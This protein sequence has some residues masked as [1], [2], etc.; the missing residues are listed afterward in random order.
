M[1]YYLSF[2]FLFRRKENEK[3]TKRKEKP[4]GNINILR[5]RR[6]KERFMPLFHFVKKPRVDKGPQP[7]MFNPALA[8]CASERIKTEGFCTLRV[9]PPGGPPQRVSSGPLPGAEPHVFC[10]AKPEK[11]RKSGLAT[12]SKLYFLPRYAS[13]TLSSLSS[14]MPV[15][16]MVTLPVWRT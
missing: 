1:F 5:E 9:L 6:K 8:T 10:K 7:L 4:K 15:P 14:S 2:S 16:V 13:F 3:E 12:F 11:T